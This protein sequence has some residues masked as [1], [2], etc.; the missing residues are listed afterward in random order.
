M[1]SV[2]H[3]SDTRNITVP[4]R[5]SRLIPVHRPISKERTTPTP[6]NGLTL[7]GTKR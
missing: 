1:D 5:L 2:G 6:L 4:L 7:T 3:A